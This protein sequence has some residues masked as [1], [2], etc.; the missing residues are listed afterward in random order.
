MVEFLFTKGNNSVDIEEQPSE[1]FYDVR[2]SNMLNNIT[3]HNIIFVNLKHHLVFR[4]FIYNFYLGTLSFS[5]GFVIG[6]WNLQ[7]FWIR[8]CRSS[9]LRGVLENRCSKIC[10]QNP[11]K[12]PMKKLIFSKVAG[13]QSATFSCIPW[14]FC[15][16]KKFLKIMFP[17]V[18]FLSKNF[19]ERDS[20]TLRK[21]NFFKDIFQGF[22]LKI[23]LGNF[24]NSCL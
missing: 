19:R 13:W 5:I 20:A 18:S 9:H 10:S 23:S 21:T 3:F 4:H 24:Q 7:W 1:Y 16:I 8:L 17:Q 12:I 15:L 22:W 6:F 2:I 14:G 11:W